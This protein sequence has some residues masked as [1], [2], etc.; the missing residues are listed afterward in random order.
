MNEKQAGMVAG[1]LG[2]EAWHSGGG[3]WLVLL[4][5]QDGRIVAVS[6]DLVCEYKDEASFFEGKPTT[7]IELPVQTTTSQR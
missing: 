4:R 6:E 7:E 3:I 1:A 5:G 2:G